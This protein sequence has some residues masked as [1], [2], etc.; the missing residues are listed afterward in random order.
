VK[1]AR[2]KMGEFKNLIKTMT[3]LLMESMKI[4]MRRSTSERQ[5]ERR[6]LVLMLASCKLSLQEL[7]RR[8]KSKTRA[9]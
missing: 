8:V 9:K 6:E 5:K 2:R 7:K 1:R 4:L 3:L